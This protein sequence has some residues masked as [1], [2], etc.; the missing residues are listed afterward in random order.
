MVTP[1][2]PIKTLLVGSFCEL[3]ESHDVCGIVMFT[4][5]GVLVYNYTKISTGIINPD[6]LAINVNVELSME[7]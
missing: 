6:T 7:A 4:H 3:A 2:V 5:D 1:P